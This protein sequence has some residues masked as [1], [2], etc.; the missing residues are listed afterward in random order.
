MLHQIAVIGDWVP[1]SEPGISDV[2]KGAEKWV[3]GI[4]WSNIDDNWILRHSITQMGRQ[5]KQIDIEVD[6]KKS[7]AVMEE[8]K[9]AEATRSRGGPLVIC[10]ASGLPWTLTEYRRKW[11]MVA[12]EAGIPQNI[13]NMDSGKADGPAVTKRSGE[14]TNKARG[15]NTN[16]NRAFWAPVKRDRTLSVL[17]SRFG[18]LLARDPNRDGSRN[19]SVLPAYPRL[20]R[21][22]S[23]LRWSCCASD[24]GGGAFLALPIRYSKP[25]ITRELQYAR[26]GRWLPFPP[27]DIINGPFRN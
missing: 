11:R 15:L 8:L 7:P 19:R 3:Q 10:E 14:R 20:Y 21:G 16:K 22:K 6:L 25:L 12:N 13:K 5:T 17:V 1:A 9:L 23:R 18:E 2:F 27:P 24:T 26:F 4:R